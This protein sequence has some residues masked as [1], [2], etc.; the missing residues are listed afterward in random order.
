M[1]A[2]GDW[3]NDFNVIAIVQEVLMVPRTWNKVR[4]DGSGKGLLSVYGVNGLRQARPFRQVMDNL[5]DQYLHWVAPISSENL[6]ARGDAFLRTN[7]R[8]ISSKAGAIMKPCRYRPL[9]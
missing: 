9:I 7:S 2:S 4:I 3:G 8:V 6:L 1:S 5:V